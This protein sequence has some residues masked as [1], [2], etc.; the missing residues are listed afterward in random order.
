MAQLDEKQLRKLKKVLLKFKVSEEEADD[1]IKY[2]EE[3]P[4]EEEPETEEQ[5]EEAKEDIEE[6]GDDEQD[7][8][9]RIDESVG[10][11][12]KLDGDED[13]Q[14]AK[15]RVDEAEG[16][17]KAVEDEKP[18][19]DE[20]IE[21]AEHE[22]LEEEVHEEVEEE[23]EEKQEEQDDAQEARILALESELT[24]IKELFEELRQKV[25]GGTFGAAAQLPPQD[26]DD[27]WVG[28]H[29]RAYFNRK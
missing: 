13:T 1:F 24:N 19:E 26:G 25:E 18:V 4:D 21:E 2:F 5:I 6:K 23:H 29:T 20:P 11:Q 9:D 14:D 8:K 27:E 22:E 28:A 12:E 16:E 7:E 3:E 17:E 10:E 15:D